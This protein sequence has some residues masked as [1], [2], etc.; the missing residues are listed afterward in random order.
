M[1][2]ALHQQENKIKQQ[3]EKERQERRETEMSIESIE[4]QVQELPHIRTE[5][6]ICSF[7]HHRGHR[8]QTSNP[9]KLKKCTDYT[10]CGLK[11]K[12]PE[13]FNKLNGLKQD[14]KKKNKDIEE[15]ENQ[16]KTMEEFLTNIIL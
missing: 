4:I 1:L 2:P 3:L 13:Y 6:I 7:C 12:H 5:R 14:L 11:D 16:L 8:N 10:F 9:C 15:L